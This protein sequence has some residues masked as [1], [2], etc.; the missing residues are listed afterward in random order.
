MTY[1][2]YFDN[3]NGQLLVCSRCKLHCSLFAEYVPI[4]ANRFEYKCQ[5]CSKVSV[6]DNRLID[7][8]AKITLEQVFELDGVDKFYLHDGGFNWLYFNPDA[9]CQSGQIVESSVCS[10][11]IIDA[12]TKACAQTE[13]SFNDYFWSWLYQEASTYLYDNDGSDLFLGMY[14]SLKND[15]C[16]IGDKSE[17]D[18]IRAL[19]AHAEKDLGVSVLTSAN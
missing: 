7:I 15:S 10:Q 3:D 17:E 13:D 9:S 2:R 18:V 11:T 6:F 14:E 5:D 8:E 19:V 4:V 12:V 16:D 1:K